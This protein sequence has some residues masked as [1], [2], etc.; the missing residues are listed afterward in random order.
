VIAAGGQISTGGGY[1]L[2]GTLGQASVGTAVDGGYVLSGGVRL[3][4]DV[5]I[6]QDETFYLPLIWGPR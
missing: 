2:A 3:H 4:H 6:A 1:T 5:Q